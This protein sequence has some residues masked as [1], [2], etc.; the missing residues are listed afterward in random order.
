MK[1]QLAV[2]EH[3]ALFSFLIIGFPVA[4]AGGAG[5]QGPR[6]L[7]AGLEK[8]SN[9]PAYIQAFSL[10]GGSFPPS[11]T[12]TL[13]PIVTL[14][15]PQAI[16]TINGLQCSSLAQNSSILADCSA[17]IQT[18]L[19]PASS[20]LQPNPEPFVC[21]EAN[22]PGNARIN[23]IA[24]RAEWNP[25]TTALDFTS[26]NS[27]IFACA[28][29]KDSTTGKFS[30]VPDPN[31]RIGA[32]G[33]C[34]AAE[35]FD[36][37][38]QGTSRFLACVRAMRADYCGNGLSLTLQG[39]PLTIYDRPPPNDLC[40]TGQCYEASWDEQGAPCINHKRYEHLLLLSTDE[41]LYGSIR[42]YILLD[43]KLASAARR[44]IEAENKAKSVVVNPYHKISYL[45]SK[46]A[47]DT[48]AKTNPPKKM[49]I[50][51]LGV[52]GTQFDP[53]AACIAQYTDFYYDDGHYMGP[54]DPIDAVTSQFVCKTGKTRI[55]QPVLTRTNVRWVVPGKL[56]ENLKCC[57]TL[58]CP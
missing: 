52:C 8:T 12:T 42:Q 2:L 44:R 22:P 33:K 35:F 47:G 25:T 24:I 54:V 29:P 28:P 20:A 23:L 10:G 19:Q 39:T 51:G 7:G 26:P 37:T 27:V 57:D 14:E 48:S 40:L 17:V 31:D 43:K 1:N 38:A 9:L 53:I 6:F 46:W 13:A 41:Q 49:T 32:F 21:T 36:P 34:V 15:H 16:F 18:T 50:D 55:P 45:A 5:T 30:K 3:L 4:G 11:A 58:P 56:P